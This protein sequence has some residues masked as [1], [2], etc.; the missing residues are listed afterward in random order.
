MN[1]IIKQRFEAL[2]LKYDGNI[3]SNQEYIDR[4]QKNVTDLW[5]NVK[6][7]LAMTDKSMTTM[8]EIVAK[9]SQSEEVPIDGKAFNLEIPKFILLD[10]GNALKN[11]LQQFSLYSL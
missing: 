8:N 10:Y 3:S 6:C 11:V 5:S 2:N 1:E 9:S 7:C 4:V